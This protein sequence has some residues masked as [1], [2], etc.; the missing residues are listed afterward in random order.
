[1]LA[2]TAFLF[3]SN[4]WR[5][6][7]LRPFLVRNCREHIYLVLTILS[8]DGLNTMHV[9]GR[10]CTSIA[11]YTIKAPITVVEV[12]DINVPQLQTPIR[13]ET[14]KTA[15]CFLCRSAPIALSVELP[16]HGFCYGDI[17]P[18]KVTLENGT[19]R[20]V[21]LVAQL[22]QVI[23][24]TAERPQVIFYIAEHH[25]KETSSV[26]A[27]IA[28][29]QLEPRTTSMWNPKELVVP[30]ASSI[31]PTLRSCGIIRIEYLLKV[32]AVNRRGLNLTVCFAVTIG[33]VPLHTSASAPNPVPMM[34]QPQ[35]VS[36]QLTSSG[37]PTQ[38]PSRQPPQRRS[39]KAGL[40]AGDFQSATPQDVAATPM[41][42]GGGM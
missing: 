23:S 42:I 2:C 30:S 39:P 27:G 10:I 21:N 33:N 12:V 41:S 3:D 40:A 35:F 25:V 4:S 36:P 14:Q 24:Y 16:R 31:V 26:V 15:S 7:C 29:G 37:N 11:D 5:T 38:I 17:I 20:Q 8:Q 22:L 18:M 34:V 9:E 1:M 28:S 32:S 19:R 6:D 13:A